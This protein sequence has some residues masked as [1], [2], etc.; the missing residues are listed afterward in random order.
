[1]RSSSSHHSH[2]H[3]HHR[4]APSHRG[5][6]NV[7]I[8]FCLSMLLTGIMFQRATTS[9]TR[10]DNEIKAATTA[11]DAALVNGEKSF[12]S[13][14]EKKYTPEIT[15]IISNIL[16]QAKDAINSVGQPNDNENIDNTNAPTSID[17]ISPRYDMDEQEASRLVKTLLNR[18]KTALT[19]AS[20]LN[21]SV[22]RFD[23]IAN[24]TTSRPYNLTLPYKLPTPNQPTLPLLFLSLFRRDSY[25][26]QTSYSQPTVP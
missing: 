25:F 16:N 8:L 22:N 19:W 20:S 26:V 4:N 10:T 5:S 9:V 12:D 17:S 6:W 14:N 21:K 15:Q 13:L 1:M 18:V 7:V 3:H 2:H 11:T 23:R 24:G